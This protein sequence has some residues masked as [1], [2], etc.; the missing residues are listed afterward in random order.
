MGRASI[1]MARG[2]QPGDNTMRNPAMLLV[3]ATI[4]SAVNLATARA[5]VLYNCGHEIRTSYYEGWVVIDSMTGIEGRDDI[6]VWGLRRTPDGRE[7][8]DQRRIQWSI[9]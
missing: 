4:L 5:D 1:R 6:W 3:L 9:D 7:I 8:I 2:A